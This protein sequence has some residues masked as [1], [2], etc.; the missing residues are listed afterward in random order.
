MAA[1]TG[2]D[3]KKRKKRGRKDRKERDIEDRMERKTGRYVDAY[4]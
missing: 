2:R 3:Q 4:G 1:A